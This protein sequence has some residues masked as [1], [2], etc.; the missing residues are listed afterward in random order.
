MTLTARI[1]VGDD[2]EA[3]AAFPDPGFEIEPGTLAQAARYLLDENH[4][5]N[6]K[7]VYPRIGFDAGAARRHLAA[8]AEER[9]RTGD[10]P[11][12]DYTLSVKAFR[13]AAKAVGLELIAGLFLSCL[14]TP[15]RARCPCRAYIEGRKT[16]PYYA[17]PQGNPDA[18]ADYGEFSILTEVTTTRRPR[19]DDINLQWKSARNHVEEAD[20][21]PRVYCFMVSR[22]GLDDR[23]GWMAAEL[24]KA[25]G[26]R[27]ALKEQAEQDGAC[28]PPDVKFLVFDIEDMA[29]IAQ[30][31][32]E[33]YCEGRS[34]AAP[35]T[36]DVLGA[37]LDRL[38]SRA[39]QRIAA[40]DNP[41]KGWAGD[42]F[43]EMLED[44]AVKRK[45]G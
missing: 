5:Q 17:A 2:P 15:A 1:L 44:H 25:Q 18:Q 23:N 27:Q 38:H 43:I 16:V 28:Q 22:L 21:R 34:R 32:D 9:R 12:T 33:L 29:E 14:D 45:P 36:E 39:M 10:E 4:T 37:L 8:L 30:K 24:L 41:P 7:E 13:I 19:K 35:L 26:E 6:M 31:L 40:G 42:T 3:A 20:A 11:E